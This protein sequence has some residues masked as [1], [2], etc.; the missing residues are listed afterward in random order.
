MLLQQ[1]RRVGHTAG[2]FTEDHARTDT[3]EHLAL[4]GSVALL[5]L[6]H[7]LPHGFS[8]SYPILFSQSQDDACPDKCTTGAFHVAHARAKGVAQITT[9]LFIDSD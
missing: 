7:D 5:E 4:C 9:S 1:L 6:G 2:A 8:S 3:L